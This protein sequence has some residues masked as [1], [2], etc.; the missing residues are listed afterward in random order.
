MY[1][2]SIFSPYVAY[3]ASLIIGS[4][5]AFFYIE[6]VIDSEKFSWA[7]YKQQIIDGTREAFKDEY[8]KYLSLYYIFVAGIA[9]SSTLYFNAYMMVGLG[10]ADSLRGLLTAGMRLINAVVIRSVLQNDSIFSWSRRILFFPAV[11]L[12]GYL[13]GIWLDGFF[14]LPF[15]QAAMIATTARWILLAPLTNQAFSS[16]Y[17]ATAISVLSLLIGVVYISL[18]SISAPVISIFGI[19]AMYSL[20]GVITLVTVI[21]LTYKLLTVGRMPEL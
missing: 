5:V 16:K 21:P 1:E 19:K 8:T 10:F 11:L 14:G 6:P 13:P 17:R 15:V 2:S 3:G 7:S 18:T 4:V 20:L 12:F 9:W